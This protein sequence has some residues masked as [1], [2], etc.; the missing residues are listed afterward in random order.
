MSGGHREGGG[1][2]ATVVRQMALR[3]PHRQA[4]DVR[5]HRMVD[6]SPVGADASSIHRIRIAQ[7]E[8]EE[9]EGS[10]GRGERIRTSGPRVPNTVLYQAELLPDRIVFARGAYNDASDATQ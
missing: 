5:N 10:F 3:F 2:S 4:A 1:E 6:R 7:A 9:R 8:G